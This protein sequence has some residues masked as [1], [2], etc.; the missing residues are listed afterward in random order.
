M[1][2]RAL[3][4]A[5]AGLSLMAGS[6]HAQQ[7][8]D[9]N[10]G[11]VIVTASPLGGDPDRFATIVE[12]VKES[13]IQAQGGSNLADALRDVP[14][15]AATSFAAGASRPVIRG[16]D[17]NRVKVL[18]DGVGSS[19]VSD[20]GP[21]HGIPID[22]LST[23]RIEVVRGA[24][25]LRYGSQAIGGVVN[26]IDNRI[27]LRLPEQA[28]EGEALIAGNSNSGTGEGG[29]HLDG[30]VG[31]LA[32]HADGYARRSSDYDTP[33][34][35]QANSFFQG[36]GYALGGSYFFNGGASR[37]GL[38]IAHYD[39]QYGIPSDDTFIQ[40]RQTKLISGSSFKIGD[41]VLKTINVD[42]GYA[43]YRH[44]EIDPAGPSLESTFKNKEWDGRIEALFGK[45]GPLSTAALGIQGGDRRFDAQGGGG[46][47]LSPSH[48]VTGAAFA[49]AEAPIGP[50]DIQSAVRVES[51]TLDG[52]PISG[53]PA[54]L[55]FTPVSASLGGSY[56]ATSNLRLGLTFTSAG[57][58]P[59]ITE[60]F[61]RGP[62]DGPLTYETGD[63]GLK[64]ERANSAETSARLKLGK[65]R[66]ELSAWTA[67]FDKY[68]YGQLTGRT[69]DDAG[70]CSVGGPGGLK[71]LNYG[72]RDATFTGLEAKAKVPLTDA[73]SLNLLGD[74]VRAHFDGGAG[75]V[76]RIQPARIGGGMDW[77]S[78]QFDAG[79]TAMRVGAQDHPG[80]LETATPGYTTLD[81]QFTWRPKPLDGVTISLVGHNLTDEVIRNAV[82]LNRDVVVQP[83][84]DIRLVAV[85]HF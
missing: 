82:A 10:L 77:K 83:G 31:N 47:Y 30:K 81:M 39:S 28:L 53:L 79:F 17:A 20:I 37:T 69:C 40:M 60:L 22:P 24:A 3:L 49:F 33:L 1:H 9:T 42:L 78:E 12:A 36:D 29:L 63:P 5:S 72:Q 50:V 35:V 73:L 68:I 45:I 56:Q 2:L 14:G 76:P 80:A 8:S 58:A 21:D 61:A 23:R 52:T 13:D 66:I 7:K 41:G 64:M 59:A 48:T 18:E 27:P 54:S 71:E 16:M 65:A 62:H 75:D 51:V 57:R 6:V 67:K 74:S 34:G 46:D 44:D 11:E 25:T 19:D 85:S 26:A 15:V 4:L 70:V 43:D 84:R 32:L 55:N 38:A